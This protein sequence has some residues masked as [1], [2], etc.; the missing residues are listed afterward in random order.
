MF[1]PHVPHGEADAAL[2]LPRKVEELAWGVFRGVPGRF[3]GLGGFKKQPLGRH[4]GQQNVPRE[5]PLNAFS[6]SR[7]IAL[8]HSPPALRLGVMDWK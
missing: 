5:P 8:A 4:R 6:G 1:L 7:A 3:R 2:E